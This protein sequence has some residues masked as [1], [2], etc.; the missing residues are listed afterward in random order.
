MEEDRIIGMISI[1]HRLLPEPYNALGHLGYSIHPQERCKGKGA[2]LLT[3]ALDYCYQLGIDCVMVST[4][5]HNAASL[6]LVEKCGGIY[7]RSVKINDSCDGYM[8]Y[9]FKNP[10]VGN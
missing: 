1:F 4:S 7:E 8:I 9:W 6:R 10:E 2:V 3:L 5:K